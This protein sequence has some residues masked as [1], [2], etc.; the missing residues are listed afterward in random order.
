MGSWHS[1]DDLTGPLDEKKQIMT[2]WAEHEMKPNTN[3]K[4]F[5]A[6][7]LMN[8]TNLESLTNRPSWDNLE[9]SICQLIFKNM[10]LQ[11]Y[12]EFCQY[13]TLKSSVLVHHVFDIVAGIEMGQPRDKAEILTNPDNC[14]LLENTKFYRIPKQ[15]CECTS[16]PISWKRICYNLQARDTIISVHIYK[17]RGTLKKKVK[18]S[19]A[20]LCF[21]T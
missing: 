11:D 5:W 17:E 19:W 1:W 15:S 16:S 20:N 3:N 2:F 8:L 18:N 13:V 14:V 9:Y 12:L 4:S 7:F 6:Q 21:T 10:R